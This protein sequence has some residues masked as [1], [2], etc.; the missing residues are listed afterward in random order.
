MPG[1]MLAMSV[2]GVTRSPTR[3]ALAAP[4]PSP[5]ASAGGAAPARSRRAARLD[6][7]AHISAAASATVASRLG[8]PGSRAASSACRLVTWR[9]RAHHRLGRRARAGARGSARAALCGAAALLVAAATSAAAGTAQVRSAMRMSV[10]LRGAPAPAMSAATGRVPRRGPARLCL[11][12]AQ[13]ALH[14]RLVV[15]QHAAP[16]LQQARVGAGQQRRQARR[17]RRRAA[18]RWRRRE[19]RGQA[20]RLAGVVQVLRAARFRVSPRSA[21]RVAGCETLANLPGPTPCACGSELCNPLAGA[22][23]QE[24]P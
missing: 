22:A 13:R 14:E 5:G 3:G 2:A 15:A 17:Q 6:G 24:G 19:Q 11:R 18:R 8:V 16:D 20:Q 1:A 7:R 4:P 10:V 23:C 21:G 9:A 12:V